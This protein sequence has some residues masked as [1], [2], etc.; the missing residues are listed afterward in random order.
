MRHLI[1][2]VSLL[3]LLVA[4]SNNGD[5][6][7]STPPIEGPG[8]VVRT[9]IPEPP[10]WVESSQIIT[11]ENVA[12][13]Q[14]LGRLDQP[15]QPSTLFAYA[16]SPDSTQLVGLNQSNIIQWDL[17]TGERTFAVGRQGASDIYYS[18]D[19]SEI[20]TVNQDGTTLIYD[21]QSGQV[22]SDFRGHEQLTVLE[23]HEDDGLLAFGGGDG[24]VK[25]WDTLER[26]SIAT[27]DAH[28]DQIIALAFSTD[29]TQLATTS[30][31]GQVNFWDWRGRELLYRLDNNGAITRRIAFSPDDQRIALGTS[32]FITLWDASTGDFLYTLQ[33][34]PGGS[35][36]ILQYSP[37]G[38]FLVNG[39]AIPDMTVWD[40][41]TGDLV[42]LLPDVGGEPISIAFSPDSSMLLV[43]EL[44]GPLNLWDMSTIT[45]ETVSRADLEV[46]TDQVLDVEWTDDGFS[47]LF[48]DAIGSVYVWG[49]PPQTQ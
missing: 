4:C 29:G 37:D 25:V 16:F 43:T 20:Y 26:R 36:D 28:E 33:T 45:K 17:I 3:L 19:K 18:P 22:I 30:S 13:T 21:S 44:N 11:R 12:D 31:D 14:L 10:D 27:I 9:L 41:E 34:G 35:T 39:G 47:M 42:A 24:T 40:A 32:E 8:G 49:V 38:K 15:G 48:F 2:L 23:Y 1:V 7:T 46:G 6:P 5:E